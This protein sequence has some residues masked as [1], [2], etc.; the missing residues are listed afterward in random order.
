MTLDERVARLER[1]IR[2]WRACATIVGSVLALVMLTAAGDA[3]A[4]TRIEALSVG[5]LQVESQ[6]GTSSITLSAAQPGGAVILMHSEN[7]KARVMLAANEVE[8]EGAASMSANASSRPLF[9]SA[10]EDRASISV[11]K[12]GGTAII[13]QER[14]DDG[15]TRTT[16]EAPRRD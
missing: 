13:L 9:A 5:R 15:K 14:G 7:G 3:D 4:P 2:R 10:P 16:F 6:S 8:G 12:T 1:S 11:G